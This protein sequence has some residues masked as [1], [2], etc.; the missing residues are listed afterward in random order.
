MAPRSVAARVLSVLDAVERASGPL[1]IT[2]IAERTGLPVAT[3]W[4]M[5]RELTEWGGLEQQADGRYRLATR[6]WAIGSS[7]PCVRRIQRYTSR[8][9]RE[10][11]ALTGRTAYLSVFDQDEALVVSL[12]QAGGGQSDVH[13]GSRLRAGA[14]SATLLYRA[15]DGPG[16]DPDPVRST[17]I[18]VHQEITGRSSMSAAITNQ[19]GAVVAALTLAGNRGEAWHQLRP[20][21]ADAAQAVRHSIYRDEL[22]V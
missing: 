16:T 7:A 12:A 17:R 3:A 13:E 6:V 21:L 20:T 8:H 5:V 18:S 11:A 14:S 22:F 4:R 19:A 1:Q 2:Q 10:L 9:I 15:F